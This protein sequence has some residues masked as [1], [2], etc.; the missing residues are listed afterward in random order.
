MKKIVKASLLLAVAAS[1]GV[2]N[3]NAKTMTTEDLNNLATIN[4]GSQEIPENLYI[5]GKYVYVN[6]ISS[7]DL[8][9]A[10]DDLLNDVEYGKTYRE[11]FTDKKAA[12]IYKDSSN[13]WTNAKDNSNLAKSTINIEMTHLI[14]DLKDEHISNKDI[15]NDG[16][17]VDKQTLPGGRTAEIF[18]D[19]KAP[20]SIANVTLATGDIELAS[21]LA[22]EYNTYN[23]SAAKVEF[24]ANKNVLTLTEDTPLLAYSNIK[25]GN[26]SQKWIPVLIKTNKPVEKDDVIKLNGTTLVLGTSMINTGSNEYLIWV[27]ETYKGVDKLT[28]QEKDSKELQKIEIAYN[29]RKVVF[30]NDVKIPEDK[31]NDVV[32]LTDCDV[33]VA[34]ATIN[35]KYINIFYTD[36]KNVKK[37]EFT[38]NG[39]KKVATRETLDETK[40]GDNNWTITE[41]LQLNSVN[42]VASKTASKTSDE[43]WNK[44]A[45][46]SIEIN[47][48]KATKD[49]DYSYVVTIRHDKEFKGTNKQVAL[50]LNLSV[51][52]ATVDSDSN[53]KNNS[54]STQY[55]ATAVYE[56][57][58]LLNESKDGKTVEFK[59]VDETLKVHFEFID[60]TPKLSLTVDKADAVDVFKGDL[61]GNAAGANQ[62]FK[63]NMNRV[64]LTTT[65][66]ETKGT[67]DVVIQQVNREKGLE[68][69]TAEGSSTY[70]TSDHKWIAVI[71]DLGINPS[72][73]AKA[74]TITKIAD[75]TNSI[76]GTNEDAKLL[77]ST[78][79]TAFVIWL[80][81]TKATYMIVSEET[82]ASVIINLVVKEIENK[83]IKDI[84]DNDNNKV[85]A[86]V[87]DEK[88]TN[89]VSYNSSTKEFTINTDTKK[90]VAKTTIEKT[91]GLEK[92]TETHEYTYIVLENGTSDNKCNFG[93]S[94]HENDKCVV[95]VQNLEL[96]GV[97]PT[98]HNTGGYAT[99]AIDT[100]TFDKNSNTVNVVFKKNPGTTNYGLVIDLGLGTDKSNSSK[101]KVNNIPE[102]NISPAGHLN[103]EDALKIKNYIV[104]WVNPTQSSSETGH[105]FA[106]SHVYNNN[107]SVPLNITVK[108]TINVAEDVTTLSEENEKVT[109]V[110]L[111]TLNGLSTEEI[112]KFV[113]QDGLTTELKDGKVYIHYTNEFGDPF[114]NGQSNEGKWFGILF[115]LGVNP[116]YLKKELDYV[117]NKKYN[118]YGIR[119]EDIEGAKRFGSKSDTA[120]MLWFNADEENGDFG[121]KD[122]ETGLPALTITFAFDPDA[123][124]AASDESFDKYAKPIDVTFVLVDD[125]DRITI[126][127]SNLTERNSSASATNF[128]YDTEYYKVNQ[129]RLGYE[130]TSLTESTAKITIYPTDSNNKTLSSF[131]LGNSGAVSP[132]EWYAISVNVGRKINTINTS[133]KSYKIDWIN[134][135]N[136]EFVLWIDH[137]ASNSDNLKLE[138]TDANNDSTYTITIENSSIVK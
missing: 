35:G 97:T 4:V 124:A 110:E 77:G 116:N 32:I 42:A 106:L 93:E 101:I 43:L 76:K 60:E 45:V 127:S 61:N 55:G 52:N 111:D 51:E 122:S 94:G 79:D 39:D 103:S 50:L 67:Y 48:H 123:V 136:G 9:D 22:K 47:E 117:G 128:T 130:F 105:Q 17:Y 69:F 119:Q 41:L 96:N 125:V 40:L 63:N 11:L 108:S 24:N 57:V 66:S 113:N 118:K 82:N 65:E 14:G 126:N 21:T 33:K 87:I 34:T 120:F 75:G 88:Y 104:I 68:S 25:A 83:T 81:D 3:V 49:E 133:S 58:Y 37:V 44:N 38:V 26:D 2:M 1:L 112:Q 99:E 138:L 80:A 12:L 36:D 54:N 64:E 27:N 28:I 20:L 46:S 72:E 91:V 18:V 71:V 23:T 59:N 114:Q 129:D 86:V 132:A 89:E 6:S 131:V 5:Y 135:E 92:K 74:L 15:Y 115:D 90:F 56:Y 84:E 29:Y 8:Q 13:K 100:I 98:I 53:F 95:K 73:E 10:M 62:S 19:E 121:I 85:T 78:S 107:E 31:S 30:S 109:D 137:K 70:F 7:A 102:Q 16:E 134:E